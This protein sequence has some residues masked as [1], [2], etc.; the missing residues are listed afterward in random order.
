MIKSFK[1][2]IYFI[3][4]ISLVFLLF[5]HTKKQNIILPL[6]NVTLK[7]NMLDSSKK[8]IISDYDKSNRIISQLNSFWYFPTNEVNGTSS[9]SAWIRIYDSSSKEIDTI[10]FYN[11]IVRY[12][13]KAYIASPST[14]IK[15]RLICSKY[16]K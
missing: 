7:I 11:F 6:D 15:L 2:L 4:I 9:P 13:D 16:G 12:R 3:I 10:Y 1:N 8:V 14:Y 5:L